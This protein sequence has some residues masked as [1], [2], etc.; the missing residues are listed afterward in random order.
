MPRASYTRRSMP[1]ATT[2]SPHAAPHAAHTDMSVERRVLL[3][4]ILGSGMAFLDGTVV[5]VSLPA[6]QVAF[7]A[8]GS[9]LQWIVEAYAL[10]LAALILA[11]GSLGDQL[12]RKRVFLAGVILFAGA[13]AWCGATNTIHAMIAARSLQGVGAA[14][15]I[16]GSLSLITAIIP[17]ERRGA[18]IGTW[19]GATALTAAGGPVIGGWLVQHVSWRGIFLLNLPFAIAVL[20]LSV[21]GYPETKQHDTRG[22]DWVGSVLASLGLGF[23]TY[24]LLE[25]PADRWRVLPQAVVGVILLALFA[26][27]EVRSPKAMAP[28]ELFRSRDFLGANLL[29]FFLYAALSA[30]LYYIPLELIQIQHRSPTSAGAALLPVV[31]MVFL[32]SR[33]SGSLVER[34][35]AA[36]PLK[37]GP[38]IVAVGMVLFA[39]P[40]LKSNYWSSWF[41]AGMVF[42][43][44]LAIS[45]APLTTIV[46]NSVTEERAGTASGVN[47]AVSRV[48]SL[49]ALAVFGVILHG[50]F[51]HALQH[52]MDAAHVAPATQQ[53]VMAQRNRLAAIDTPDPQAADAV[54]EAFLAGFRRVMILGAVLCVMSS[55]SAG[56]L[57]GGRV[58]KAA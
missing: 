1:N 38:S 14:L 2:D 45:V 35:G 31:I 44:G 42:G 36:L 25:F 3:V 13:S 19:S 57:S 55:I 4:A 10:M 23:V 58:K 40:G 27:V 26:S 17:E 50:T 39:L 30:V 24:S 12:G 48:A 51:V 29:T 41:P 56:L 15:L 43:F 16:P 5:N 7:H 33:W 32:L 28:L 21:R 49:L 6:L 54:Q 37:I 46:M 22:I 18:A 47:N 8:T 11:G 52:R 53:A 20:W 34:F 9:Q